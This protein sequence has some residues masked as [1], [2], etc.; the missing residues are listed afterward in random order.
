MLS[1]LLSHPV[2]I[3]TDINIINIFIGFRI[4]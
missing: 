2:S 1:D 4:K 3:S